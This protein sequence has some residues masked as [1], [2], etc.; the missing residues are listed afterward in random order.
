MKNRERILTSAARL[1]RERGFGGINVAQIIGS[2]GTDPW[3][4]LLWLRF[5][6]KDDLIA[7]MLAKLLLPAPGV[8]DIPHDFRDY[9]SSYLE[10]AAPGRDPPQAAMPL[11]RA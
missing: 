3:S 10:R 7:Q 1:F 8:S 2:V 9:A 6:S 4:H 11:R 5:K